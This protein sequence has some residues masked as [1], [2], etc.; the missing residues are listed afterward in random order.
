MVIGVIPLSSML[1]FY[2]NPYVQGCGS[3]ELQ[4]FIF[5]LCLLV[6]D[7]I[8]WTNVICKNLGGFS[9]HMKQ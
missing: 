7:H 4:R 3:V 2:K 6:L 5:H 9:G 1:D 8:S